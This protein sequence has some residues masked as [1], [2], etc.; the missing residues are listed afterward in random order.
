LCHSTGEEALEQGSR[1]VEVLEPADFNQFPKMSQKINGY[2]V[3]HGNNTNNGCASENGCCLTNGVS[4]I[5][6][7]TSKNGYSSSY[8]CYKR[9]RYMDDDILR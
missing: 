7:Y 4:S 2:A 6:G 3:T 1:I 9:S 8:S 5:N